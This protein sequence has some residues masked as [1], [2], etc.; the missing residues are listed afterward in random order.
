M[1][2]GI[3]CYVYVKLN[4]MIL[5]N[6][7]PTINCCRYNIRG[8]LLQPIFQQHR[9]PSK[10]LHCAGICELIFI[11]ISL[12]SHGERQQ[13]L[14]RSPVFSSPWRDVY[15]IASRECVTLTILVPTLWWRQS[16]SLDLTSLQPNLKN[17]QFTWCTQWKRG[18][19]SMGP[20]VWPRKMKI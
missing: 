10:H 3:W 18:A 12:P 14:A 17:K 7:I 6:Y 11:C 20:W 13:K 4:K 19:T 9:P 1:S 2:I 16:V 5:L 15:V 8:L